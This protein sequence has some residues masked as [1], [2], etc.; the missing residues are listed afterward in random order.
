MVSLRGPSPP[1]VVGT[2]ATALYVLV[3]RP[4]HLRWGAEPED[5]ER[6]LPGVHA[7]HRGDPA[8]RPARAGDQPDRGEERDRV[9]LQAAR[10]RRLEQPEETRLFERLDRLGRDD[11]GVLGLLGALSQGGKQFGDSGD[12]SLRSLVCLRAGPGLI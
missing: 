9:R 3:I 2:G 1:A 10:G 12:N 7:D 8:G 5:E 11:A 6:E 4:W